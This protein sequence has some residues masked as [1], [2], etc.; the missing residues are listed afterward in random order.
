MDLGERD[1]RPLDP[2]LNPT[3]WDRMVGNVMFAAAGE[4]ERRSVMR[5][6]LLIVAEWFR[7]ALGGSALI[8]VSALALL[9]L[10][11]SG[12][13]QIAEVGAVADGIGLPSSIDTWLST[14]D[15]DALDEL[16]FVMEEVSQ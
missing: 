2:E 1:L 4:L 7:P 8:A 16:V 3:Q 12:S 15:S 6:P 14:G 5:S 10:E 9:V 11:G 13:E